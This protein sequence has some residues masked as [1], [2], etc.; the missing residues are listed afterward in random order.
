MLG[1]AVDD[2]SGPAKIMVVVETASGR[3]REVH[4]SFG[5]GASSSCNGTYYYDGD[6]VVIL[7]SN[8]TANWWLRGQQFRLRDAIS[9]ITRIVEV[10]F[11]GRATAFEAR[12]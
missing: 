9:D 12:F 5:G 6:R 11:G 1:C 4:Y 2:F 3:L 8:A 7:R 10:R